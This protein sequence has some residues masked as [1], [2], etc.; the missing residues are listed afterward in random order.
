MR[1]MRTSAAV[2]KG[3]LVSEHLYVQT[4]EIT[5]AHHWIKHAETTAVVQTKD[6]MATHW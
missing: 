3:R 2:D 6:V 5:A 1:V 4:H